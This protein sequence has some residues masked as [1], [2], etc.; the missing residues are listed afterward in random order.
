MSTNRLERDQL[1]VNPHARNAMC[2]KALLAALRAN[3]P[4]Q[5]PA[6]GIIPET[7]PETKAPIP[8]SVI[9][10]ASE[11]AFPNFPSRI[12]QIQLATL[13]LFPK[14]TRAELTSSRRK[15]TVVKARQI[16]MYISKQ[17]TSQSLPEIGR[18]FGGRDHTTVLHAVRKV[19]RMVETDPI[20]AAQI[21]Q[22][23]SL[24]PEI[25]T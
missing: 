14:I 13:T 24:I 8:N 2:S 6:P 1:E 12:K 20:L 11:I 3:H 15:A 18:R 16:A 22:I 25:A 5:E 19:E 23:K 10:A 7:I 17:L 4:E 21:E 9:A